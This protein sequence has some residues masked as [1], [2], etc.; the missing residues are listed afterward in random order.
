ML[1]WWSRLFRHGLG[2]WQSVL[3]VEG[4][5]VY[6]EVHM[7]DR[8]RLI[9]LVVLFILVLIGTYGFFFRPDLP[10]RW[11]LVFGIGFLANLSD[12]LVRKE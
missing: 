7:S 1:A 6:T 12:L 5:V 2:T 9:G 4:V 10:L 8:I 3:P 11:L